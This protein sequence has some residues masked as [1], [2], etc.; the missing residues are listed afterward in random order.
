MPGRS[1][2]SR[3]GRRQLHRSLSFR[4][5]V[6]AYVPVVGF[7]AG[8]GLLYE[9]VVLGFRESTLCIMVWTDVE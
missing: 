6:D 1:L 9:R 3:E 7:G 2:P 4:S 5:C 8:L